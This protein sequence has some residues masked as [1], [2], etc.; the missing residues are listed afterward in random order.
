MPELPEVETIK[1]TVKKAINGG[2]IRRVKV[3]QR[4]LRDMVPAD[5]SQRIEGAKIIDMRRIAKYMLIDLDNHLTVI[6]HFGMSGK[7][8]IE[9]ICPANPQKHDHII[10]ETDK[11]V[12]VYNDA[13]RFG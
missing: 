13:R 1:N 10:I 5:F 9:P 2:V 12:L 7:F 8:R 6:C 11:G 3:N 4:R